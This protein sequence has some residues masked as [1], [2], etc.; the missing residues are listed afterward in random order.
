MTTKPYIAGAAYVDKMSDYC[1][2]CAF[3]PKKPVAEGGC[4]LTSLYWAYLQRHEPI[5]RNNER[6]KLPLASMR[7]RSELDHDRVERVY[8]IT[9]RA[10][11]RGEPLTPASYAAIALAEVPGRRAR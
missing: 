8:Q 7:K 3:S 11:G 9:R 4:P 5:L 2:G 6:L 10:L 1:R